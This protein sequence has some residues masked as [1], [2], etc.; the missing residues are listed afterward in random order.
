MRIFLVLTLFLSTEVYSS[1]LCGEVKSKGE[2]HWPI[3]ETEFTQSA[4][5]QASN[6]LQKYVSELNKGQE[7]F[8]QQYGADYQSI[9]FN[10]LVLIKGYTLKLSAETDIAANKKY[11]KHTTSKFCEFLKNEAHVWH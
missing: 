5:E 3:P 9:V 6:K 4:A 10:E 11:A 2:G 1:E 8:A 7:Y